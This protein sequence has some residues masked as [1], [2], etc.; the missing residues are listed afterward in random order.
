MAMQYLRYRHMLSV[1]GLFSF[2]FITLCFYSRH[3]HPAI[4]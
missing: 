2:A 1:F 4:T 3:L